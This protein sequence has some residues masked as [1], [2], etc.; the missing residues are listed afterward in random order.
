MPSQVSLQPGTCPERVLSR[1]R[2]RKE[3]RTPCPASRADARPSLSHFPFGGAQSH[4][5]C[6]HQGRDRLQRRALPPEP[7]LLRGSGHRPPQDRRQGRGPRREGDPRPN[8]GL[9]PR[10]SGGDDSRGRQGSLP[11]AQDRS[12]DLRPLH[13]WNQQGHPHGA[14]VPHVRGGP[15]PGRVLRLHQAAQAS[16]PSLLGLLVDGKVEVPAG[17]VRGDRGE[18][19]GALREQDQVL[20]AGDD[21]RRLVQRGDHDHPGCLQEQVGGG[22]EPCPGLAVLGPLQGRGGEVPGGAGADQAGSEQ[23]EAGA[24]RSAQGCVGR[25][26]E[27]GEA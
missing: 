2:K 10:K 14:F 16:G 3:K 19:Q 13:R 5:R 1:A 27:E 26:A 6:H 24:E 15:R 21:W 7:R 23:P 9:R 22:Q 11:S 20:R 17:E 8:Q 12:Q 25:A 4:G 18:V